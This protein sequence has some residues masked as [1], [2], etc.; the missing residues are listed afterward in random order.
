MTPR[1]RHLAVCVVLAGFSG[2][3][4][5]QVPGIPA[6]P[7][8]AG[9]GLGGAGLGGAGLGGAGLGGAG[10]SSVAAAPRTLWGFFGL[11][12]A[13]LGACKAKLCASPVGTMLN[14][15]LMPFSS[16]TGGLI[17]MCCPTV[18]SDA[19]VAALAAAGG[20]TGPE[21]VAAKIKQ[22]E[23]E[24][25]AR[26]A[27]VRYL[28]TVDCHYWPEA[29]AA[30]ITAL[31]DDRNECVRYEAAMALLNGCCC[32][33]KT[34]EALN[35]VVSGS[36]KD[37]KPSESSERVRGVSLSALQRCMLRVRVPAEPVPLERPEPASVTMTMPM[38]M[39]TEDL[40][41][42]FQRVEYYF[43]T[44]K[45]VPPAVI[46]ASA[47][48]TLARFGPGGQAPVATETLV[49]G[50][51]SVLHALTRATATAAAPPTPAPARPA[52]AA[53]ASG[54]TRAATPDKPAEPVAPMVG[55]V[56]TLRP[57]RDPALLQTAYALATPTRA[58]PFPPSP[59]ASPARS[60]AASQ[61][62]PSTGRRNLRDI[63]RDSIGLTVNR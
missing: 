2:V 46:V 13:N 24:A 31:R 3:A 38:T 32:T 25:K 45:S 12:A 63:V 7:G 37:G 8:G 23:A 5:A 10:I 56:A 34:V 30:L 39:T 1:K 33:T 53:P 11:S 52:P 15:T 17:P 27:A 36:E 59:S 47:K 9:A 26:R 14:S 22:D 44:L 57:T 18:P 60:T 21:A 49:T 58:K 61:S 28:S 6:L 19:Q 40:P 62:V 48:Q 55:E 35:I 29:E 54:G 51:R 41:P 20:P 42:G 16:M 4:R 43:K 50:E